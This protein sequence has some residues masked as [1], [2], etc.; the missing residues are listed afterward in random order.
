MENFVLILFL[1]ILTSEAV[2]VN[3]SLEYKENQEILNFWGSNYEM[4]FAQGYLL[5]KRITDFF[6]EFFFE[7]NFLSYLEYQYLRINYGNY[8]VVP[9]KYEREARGILDGIVASGEDLYIGKLYREL[10]VLDFLRRRG[11]RRLLF[12]ACLV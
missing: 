9:Q 2:A 4:G 10:D 6:S 7:I 1:L 3:G 5:N 11:A 8:F 12:R